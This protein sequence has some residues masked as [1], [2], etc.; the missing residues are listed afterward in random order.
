MRN[1][2]HVE[3]A[4]RMV[5][6]QIRHVPDT[7]RDAL[8]DEAR[9]RQ[10]SLQ[11]YLLDVLA[12]EA[13]LASNRRWLERHRNDPPVRDAPPMRNRLLTTSCRRANRVALDRR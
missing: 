10:H 11:V 3:Y 12:H 6:L 2:M 5:A 7:I 1:R 9:R 8:V 4:R 13:A